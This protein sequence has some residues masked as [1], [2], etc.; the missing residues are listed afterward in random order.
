MAA[1]GILAAIT[2]GLLLHLCFF[3]IYISFLGL[4]TYEYIRQQRTTQNHTPS[5]QVV[6]DSS[7]SNLR[8]RPINLHCDSRTRSTLV[9]CT[10][11]EETFSGCGVEPTPTPPT[12]PQDC[13]VCVVNSVAPELPPR[14]SKKLKTKWNC[15]LAVPDSPDSPNEPRCLM[16][17]C[18]HK[19]KSKIEGR[20]HGHWSS[21]KLRVFFRVLGNFT[22]I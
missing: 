1:L 2:A 13:Q 6:E 15:C 19:M 17:I 20:T 9:T 14:P 16:N 3:H 10:V 8:H 22:S 4:T 5:Q 18:K 12:T 11:L 7:S 21:A